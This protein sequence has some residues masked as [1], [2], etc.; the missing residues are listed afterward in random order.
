MTDLFVMHGTGN[1]YGIPGASGACWRIRSMKTRGT[2]PGTMSDADLR[3]S[4]IDAS[5]D[6]A[7][8]A[9]RP[10]STSYEI[11]FAT[12]TLARLT[13]ELR[14]RDAS[15]SDPVEMLPE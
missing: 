1:N 4:I 14:R 15:A 6:V 7:K 10:S 9:N 13:H 5:L 8:E 12:G 2:D 3:A 11:H